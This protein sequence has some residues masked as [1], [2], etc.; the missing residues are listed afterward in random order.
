MIPEP[1]KTPVSEVCDNLNPVLH[2]SLVPLL[3][4]TL[5][6]TEGI[7]QIDFEFQQ[8]KFWRLSFAIFILSF[9]EFC[10]FESINF[11]QDGA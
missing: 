8:A 7:I 5:R 10:M 6:P 2:Y 1:F 3:T 11:M 9:V 4:H